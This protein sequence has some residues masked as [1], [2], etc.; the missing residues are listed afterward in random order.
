MRIQCKVCGG[1]AALHGVVDFNKSC[2]IDKGLALPLR[3]IPVWYHRCPDCGFLFTAQFDDWTADDWRREVYNDEY[4]TVDPDYISGD[5][6]RANAALILDAHSRTPIGA[7]LDY[8]G[9][10]GY[11]AAY[12][13][14]KGLDATSFD[15]LL[16]AAPPPQG[17]FGLVTAFEVF[18]HTATPIETARDALAFLRPDGV[19][20]FS[21]LTCDGLAPQKTDWAY[22]APR[23]GHVSIHSLASL[24]RMFSDLGW[25]LQHIHT[26]LHLATA[27]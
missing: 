20:L 6:A 14:D 2:E 23:N 22:L 8:G 5:R 1:N 24:D 10:D 18:E 13:R 7:M 16:D 21:T 4:R 9:G 3:G 26:G 19:L 12:L 11:L 27:R 25:K 15:P 17:T